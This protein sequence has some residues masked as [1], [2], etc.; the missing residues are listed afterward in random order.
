MHT[1]TVC[2]CGVAAPVAIIM[3]RVNTPRLRAHY[4]RQ[5]TPPL[6]SQLVVKKTPVP[7][8]R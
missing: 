2:Y 6:M 4:R 3:V 8:A 1:V 7:Y 5:P